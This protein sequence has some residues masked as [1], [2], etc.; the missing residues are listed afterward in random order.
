MSA[1]SDRVE[2]ERAEGGFGGTREEE[3]PP[4][5]PSVSR[6]PGGAGR[7]QHLYS[8]LIQT[9]GL[10]IWASDDSSKHLLNVLQFHVQY[11]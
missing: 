7:F 4:T 6:H 5:P 2:D 1:L 10:R 3:V 11:I 8:F 9:S